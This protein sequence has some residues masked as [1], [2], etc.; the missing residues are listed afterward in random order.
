MQYLLI[1]VMCSCHGFACESL[2][3]QQ[4]AIYMQAQRLVAFCRRALSD[5]VTQSM[6][7]ADVCKAALQGVQGALAHAS[8]ARCDALLAA[9]TSLSSRAPPRSAV[10]A[11]CL[12]FQLALL[13]RGGEVMYP[14]PATGIPLLSH[15]V[16]IDW[17]Q[18]CCHPQ[19]LNV[20]I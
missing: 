15:G 11:A 14:K 2:L 9:V 10:K 8:P 4:W 18:V 16:L 19:N 6:M 7:P 12:D 20:L 3:S 13:A 1:I 17:L 5:D